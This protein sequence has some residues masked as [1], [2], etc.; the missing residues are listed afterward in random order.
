MSLL[1]AQKS[2][3]WFVNAVNL[4]VLSFDSL[5]N[6]FLSLLLSFDRFCLNQI[7]Y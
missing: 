4:Y 5:V 3:C 6:S 1:K 2:P 7:P